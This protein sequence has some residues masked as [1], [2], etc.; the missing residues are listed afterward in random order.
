MESSPALLTVR[1]VICQVMLFTNGA[2]CFVGEVAMKLYDA[3]TSIQQGKRED[4]FGWVVPIEEGSA[5]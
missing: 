2:L 3:L 1:L 4:K 5:K